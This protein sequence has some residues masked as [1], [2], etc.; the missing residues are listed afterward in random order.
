MKACVQGCGR[1]IDTYVGPGRS[2]ETGRS[3]SR[4]RELRFVDLD[5]LMKLETGKIRICA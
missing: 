1:V 4:W 5:I 3:F 2:D